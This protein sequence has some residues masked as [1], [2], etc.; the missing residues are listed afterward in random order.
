MRDLHVGF[1]IL[2]PVSDTPNKLMTGL[3]FFLDAIGPLAIWY[4]VVAII[5][6][7]AVSGAPRKSV[8]WVLGGLYLVLMVCFATLGAMFNRGG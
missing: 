2:L 5:G 7:A 8:G 1:G 3:G 6:A 4:L